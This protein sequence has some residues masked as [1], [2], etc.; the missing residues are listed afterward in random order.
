MPRNELNAPNSKRA[1]RDLLNELTSERIRGQAAGNDVVTTLE[2]Q[3]DDIDHRADERLGDTDVAAREAVSDVLAEQEEHLDRR[4]ASVDAINS[5][6]VDLLRD[7]AAGVGNAARMSSVVDATRSLMGRLDAVDNMSLR[8]VRD[9]TLHALDDVDP[10]VAL[11]A[12]AARQEEALEQLER[13]YA[14]IL[15]AFRDAALV[16]A[17]RSSVNMAALD[18]RLGGTALAASVDDIQ[19]SLA[20][21][22]EALDDALLHDATRLR[23]NIETAWAATFDQTVD[24]SR[25]PIVG[26]G[27][28]AVTPEVRSGF[29]A[30]HVERLGELCS[31]R[32][33]DVP[34]LAQLWAASERNDA[35]ATDA[36]SARR[37]FNRHVAAFWSAVRDAGSVDGA[38]RA[39]LEQAGLTQR[40]RRR[41]GAAF[42]ETD[43]GTCI[44]VSLDHDNELRQRPDLAQRAD[45]LRLVFLREH[46][47]ALRLL[48][49]YDR[50]QQQ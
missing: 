45:N 19:Q 26:Q 15:S 50:K 7:D 11:P 21:L 13:F 38:V 17:E 34:A 39:T 35:V 48:N 5:L 37:E 44:K 28:V 14:E 3:L 24:E 8:Q 12:V 47:V 20:T 23:Q 30:Q 6:L 42:Y 22:R 32:I 49:H 36:T 31:K 43:D 2:R 9:E 1:E 40:D 4:R 33:S 29:R 41:P 46:V 10:Q 18:Q 25:S 16:D 27:V